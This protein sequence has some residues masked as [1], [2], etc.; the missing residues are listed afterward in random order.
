MNLRKSWAQFGKGLGRSGA[1][2][3]RSRAPLG[4]FRSVQNLSFFKHGSKIDSKR[5]FGSILARFWEG[6]GSI[7][8]RIWEDFGAFGQV[9]GRLGVWLGSKQIWVVLLRT[10][11]GPT[12]RTGTPVSPR[13]AP[14][15]VTIRGGSVELQRVLGKVL[16][17]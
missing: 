5:L 1:F 6:L 10:L 7:W 12:F 2:W 9:G 8:R 4:H 15:S 13:Y 17:L 14:R 11:F 16:D 3:G